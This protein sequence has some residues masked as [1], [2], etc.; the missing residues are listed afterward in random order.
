MLTERKQPKS[1]AL[2]GV[3]CAWL[4][5]DTPHNSMTVTALLVFDDPLDFDD[6][7]HLVTTRLL[8][9][10]RFRQ[11]VQRPG[12]LAR[13]RWQLVDDFALDAHVKRCTL[14]PDADLHTLVARL[15]NDPLDPHEP[16]WDM[17]LV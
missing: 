5:L 3:D 2:T 14:A 12:G 15:L 11:R 1:E 17:H 7:R 9:F 8:P 16:L 4:R 10:R 6:L 13:P